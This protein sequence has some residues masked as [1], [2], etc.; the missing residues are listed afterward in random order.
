LRVRL[1]GPSGIASAQARDR[2]VRG[3]TGRREDLI[4]QGQ[5]NLY[6]DVV[7]RV[8]GHGARFQS[9]EG[10]VRVTYPCVSRRINA[11]RKAS[12]VAVDVYEPCVNHGLGEHVHDRLVHERFPSGGCESMLQIDADCNLRLVGKIPQVIHVGLKGRKVG[13]GVV[14][15]SYG[16][17]HPLVGL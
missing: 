2:R 7:G 14:S 6:A 16:Q 10:P 4:V 13:G 17:H 3:A 9:V 1:K 8:R 15:N 11:S 12:R 5:T